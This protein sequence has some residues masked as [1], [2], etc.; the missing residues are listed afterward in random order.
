MSLENNSGITLAEL[1]E[2]FRQLGDD[3]DK[4]CASALDV[5]G[6]HDSALF[7]LRNPDIEHPMYLWLEEKI[8]E[9]YNL[10]DQINYVA[11]NRESSTSLDDSELEGLRKWKERKQ[12]WKEWGI[13]GTK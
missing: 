7:T 11:N 6:R 1:D 8:A 12:K 13:G 9:N 10:V 5:S 4:R 2:R 3:V